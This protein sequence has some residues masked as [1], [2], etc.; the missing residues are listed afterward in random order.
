MSRGSIPWTAI[1]EWSRSERV[2]AR[3]RFEYLIRTM[4][5]ALASAVDKSDPKAEGQDG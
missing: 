2:V 3:E 1:R 5:T 4:D